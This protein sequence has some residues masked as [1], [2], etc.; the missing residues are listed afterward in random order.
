MTYE[1]L[2]TKSW[3]DSNWIPQLN[4]H[5]VLAY[6]CQR[7]NLF[8]DKTCNNEVAKMQR[9]NPSQLLHMKGKSCLVKNF[10]TSVSKRI[11]QYCK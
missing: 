5:N 9:L 7:S 2:M 10:V 4:P 8:Y 6:F 1:N 3:K 11:R